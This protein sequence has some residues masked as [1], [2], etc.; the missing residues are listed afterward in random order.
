MPNPLKNARATATELEPVTVTDNVP[1]E[2]GKIAI[3][4]LELYGVTVELCS[5]GAAV[6]RLLLPAEGEHVD[7]V[8]GFDSVTEMYESQ[9][10]VYFGVT[11]GRVANRIRQG[12]FQTE[13][14]GMVYQLEINN[15]P[16]H[17]H[18][19]VTGFSNRI[20]DA[21]IIR[22]RT[23]GDDEQVTFTIISV[24]G[25]QGYPGTVKVTASYSLQPTPSVHSV[26]L[27]LCMT[28]ELLDGTPTPIN[29][30]QHSYFNLAGHDSSTGILDHSLRLY[31][32]AY[33]PVDETSIPTREVRPLDDDP[34]MD[35][36][37]SRSLRHA[38]TEYGLDKKGL[39][40]E[41]VHADL[42][43]RDA[44]LSAATPY[45]FDHNYVIRR[46]SASNHSADH[47]L[48]LVAVLQHGHRRLTVRSTQPG[49]QVYTANYLDGTLPATRKASSAKEATSGYSRWQGLCLETQH[50]PDSIL[51]DSDRHPKFGAG[52]CPILTPDSPH[53]KHS[54]EYTFENNPWA[55]NPAVPL[56]K[57]FHGSDSDGNHY[58][59]VEEMW[60]EQGVT[61][62]NSTVWYERAA[63]YYEENCPSTIDGV[64]GGF[65]SIT[66]MDLAGS[67][68]FIHELES[69][70]PAVRQW[71][72]D[73]GGKGQK[74][75]A[76]ECGAGLG[77]VTKGLL[78]QLN[79]I[80]QCDLVESSATLLSAAPEY[81]GDAAAARCRFFCTGLQDWKPT[82]STYSV[83]W[84]QW[85]LSYL[86]D[87]DIVK[88]L[89]RCGESLV[90]DGV[91]V[92]KENTCEESDFEVDVEDASVT[93]SLRYW[94]CLIQRAGLRI[95]HEK[96]Q[97]NL[98]TDIYPVPMLA[99][100]RG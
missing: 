69:L 95:V 53:Y 55:M 97:D 26:K 63:S 64:L 87:D 88:F 96:M 60:E 80:D 12:R 78:F 21:E 24:D 48:S 98:P 89:L 85:V 36:R 35:W 54:I 59:S 29:L 75:L 56:T 34:V 49:V 91:I 11:P 7:V 57:G 19:G 99:L 13:N 52:Q 77:R 1:V 37:S 86:T 47:G 10:P 42:A 70:R 84:T 82:V 62:G 61:E 92:L 8:L 72:S 5:L 93:R 90:E 27:C 4:R 28:A 9:N 67:M 83:V 18:G 65:A 51:V 31:C 22:A 74:R 3:F 2:H 81:L 50:F 46:F 17:L 20:W 41:H 94:K 76:C 66:D 68:Q 14:D 30:T 71:S 44:A 6:T 25:D 38:L 40:L 32:D 23:D 43:Q 45:G 33:T 100:E 79:G 16:N 39:S 73:S 15:E 58:C